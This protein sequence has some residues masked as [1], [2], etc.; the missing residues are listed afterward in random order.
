MQ[1][2]EIIGYGSTYFPAKVVVAV[3]IVASKVWYN[4]V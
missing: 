3:V 1:Y 4:R 2:L